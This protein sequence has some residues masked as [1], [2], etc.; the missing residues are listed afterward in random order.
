MQNKNWKETSRK[1]ADW[2]K[3]IEKM[4]VDIGL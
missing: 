1:G 2:E 4:K 3:S